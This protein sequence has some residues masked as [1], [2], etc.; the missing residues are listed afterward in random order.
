M[1]L[2]MGKPKQNTKPDLPNQGKSPLGNVSRALLHPV[3][4]HSCSAL[5]KDPVSGPAA[6]TPQKHPERSPLAAS[7][8]GTC[9]SLEGTVMFRS[10]CR[11]PP[12]DI[13]TTALKLPVHG[14]KK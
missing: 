12:A 9:P 6:G 14:A 3:L 13:I 7:V 4:S 5:A 11:P 2:R 1:A 10:C 8:P